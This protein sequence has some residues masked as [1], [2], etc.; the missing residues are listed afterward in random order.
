MATID[1]VI[2]K[3]QADVAD[4]K[5]GLDKAEASLRG[6]DDTV[7]KADTT[8]GTFGTR[9]K[10]LGATI[11]VT[12]ATGQVVAFFRE[13]IDAAQQAEAAQAR[14]RNLLLNTNGATEAQI[15]ALQ[16]QAKA[17]EKVGVVSADNVTVAQSQLATFDLSA[18]AIGKLTPAI[19]NY[20][21]AEKGANASTE[22]LKMMTNGL[23]QALNGNFAS[24][25]RTGFVLDEATKKQISHG[26]EMERAEAIVRVLN[27]TYK[28]FNANLRNTSEGAMQVAINDFNNLKQQ[29]GEG[30][31][32]AVDGFARFLSNVLIPA[33]S[34]VVTF[35]QENIKEIKAFAAVIAFGASA[36]GL[37]VVAINAAKVAQAAFNV[38]AN[39]NPYGKIVTV[40][41][42]LVAGLVKL[43]NISEGFRRVV[44][45]VAQAG[46]RAFASMIP[47]I[48]DLGEAL[49]RVMTGPLRTF[50]AILAKIPNM[51]RFAKSGLDLLNK[52]I[53]S[54]S[55]FGD[56][57]SAKAKNLANDLEKLVKVSKK[58]GEE[59]KKNVGG[60][61]KGRDEIP[62]PTDPKIL[63]QLESYKNKVR[64]IQE[65]YLEQ[66]ETL[67]ERYDERLLATQERYEEDVADLKAR[68]QKQD[69][70]ARKSYAKRILDITKAYNNREIDLAENLAEKLTDIQKSAESQRQNLRRSAAE[71]EVALAQ[72]SMNRL[73][74][75]FAQGLNFSLEDTM[76]RGG[77]IS[78]ALRRLTRRLQE[79]KNLQANAAALAG[80]GYSQTFIE[81]IVKA[82]P[83]VGN[84]M[85]KSI[86][87]AS[88]E[89]TKEMQDLFGQIEKISETGL[90][91]LATTM[92]KG[93]NLA[94]REL[95]EAYANVA[96]DL[97]KSLVQVDVALKEGLAEAQAE[98]QKAMA[99]T[100]KSRADAMLEASEDLQ[101]RLDENT[102]Q[103]R[104][105]LNDTYKDFQKA[106][107][108]IYN[109]FNKNLADSYDDLVEAL[110][111][112]RKAFKD[113]VSETPGV[114]LPKVSPVAPYVPNYG[115][116]TPINTESTPVSNVT[117]NNINVTA[118]TEAD[119]ISIADA[120]LYAQKY[121]QVIQVRELAIR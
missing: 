20:V 38:V 69:E 111:K 114:A 70:S 86:L 120:I 49:V 37:F 44:I 98:Y 33:L 116:F 60:F 68:K 27:T 24:L 65:A 67:Q 8:F 3:I 83:R 95:R 47:T 72:Q 22:E 62:T 54:I 84:R 55:D 107:N 81:E 34:K 36:W 29:I 21:T 53:D 9:L 109:D 89:S 85:A 17:L 19:L 79:A 23:A 16:D 87:A 110:K 28:D 121:G 74:I 82:G 14:L 45:N 43:Y 76:Q 100:A 118:S 94:T 59:T 50:L 51:G 42:L 2:V 12:F 112:A 93:G 6:L 99:D 35:I 30:L 46:L 57:A 80:R 52:G 71:K 113:A 117:N 92:N 39:A 78:G 66:T 56:K 58:A 73:R 61:G 4:L 115:Q 96:T 103:L 32:P 63:R 119:P 1:P 88:P 5:A 13:S 105:A 77:G 26:S 40:V 18:A 11:G 101:E 15:K 25:T 108:D 97:Q 104:E 10:Q 91:A 64:D 31:K 7:K 106:Q 48:T 90:D 102:Q 75:A 41:A